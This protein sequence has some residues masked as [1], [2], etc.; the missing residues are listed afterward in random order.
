MRAFW[1]A[2]KQS[3]NAFIEDDCMT[4]GAA[5]AYYS[6]F[7]L[8]PLLIF[9]FMVASAVGV[10]DQDITRIMREQAGLPVDE[11][12]TQQLHESGQGD[13]PEGEETSPTQSFAVGNM[14]IA[15]QLIG[16]GIILF[17]AT[18]VFAQL[19]YSLNQ[20]WQVEP[21]PQMGGIKNFVLKRILSLGMILVIAFLLLVSL[22]ITA[23]IQEVVKVLSGPMQAMGLELGLAIVLNN[24]ATMAVATILF[25]A[26]YKLMPDG[27]MAWKDVWVGSAV[28][29]LLFLIGKAALGLYL[30]YGNIGSTWGTAAASIIIILVWVYY[31]SMIVLFG[32]ELTQVWANR[33]G[34][35]IEP[36]YAAVRTVT[37][38]KHLRNPV[39]QAHHG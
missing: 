33:F 19:Q 11:V 24:V 37:E 31:S 4:S 5:I 10:S 30:Q 16:L 8:P 39:K 13:A 21:D 27:K 12:I 35:G 6:S 26:M 36:M 17:S 34:N 14:G 9:V 28:T 2:I 7:S 20:A 23:L 38:K 15:S 29:A 22:V 25:A 18:G 3:V 32:A 1:D